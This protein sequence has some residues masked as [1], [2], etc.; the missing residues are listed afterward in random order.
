VHLLLHDPRRD[1]CDA[2]DV[3]GVRDD[4]GHTCAVR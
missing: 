3:H 4:R 1:V 2:C